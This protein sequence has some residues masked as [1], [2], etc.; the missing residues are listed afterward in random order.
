MANPRGSL[1]PGPGEVLG[2]HVSR[3]QG[4]RAHHHGPVPPGPCLGGHRL[5]PSLQDLPPSLLPRPPAAPRFHP[6]FSEVSTGAQALSSP[7][8]DHRS[9][10]PG[11]HPGRVTTGGFEER[12]AT[13]CRCRHPGPFPGCFRP[14]LLTR[15]RAESKVGKE[16][17]A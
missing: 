17:K 2:E 10:G 8:T 14:R 13:L 7:T 6:R 16:I 5:F 12:R 9:R 4:L 1:C 3:C 15:F 11:G